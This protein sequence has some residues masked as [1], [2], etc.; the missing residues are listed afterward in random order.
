MA[1]IPLAEVEALRQGL[2]EAGVP[3]EI[4]VYEDD[5]VP[6]PEHGSDC[7]RRRP[8]RSLAATADLFYNRTC[9]R[10]QAQPTHALTAAEA[11]R[12]VDLSLLYIVRLALSHL[13]HRG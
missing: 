10:V 1:A 9:N 12:A 8:T 6:C 7:Q 11:V 4:T 3:N 5:P 13:W 2:Q